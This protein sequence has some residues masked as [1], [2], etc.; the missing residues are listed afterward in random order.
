VLILIANR[1]GGKKF[2]VIIEDF[3]ENIIYKNVK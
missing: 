2:G 3:Y 1:Y